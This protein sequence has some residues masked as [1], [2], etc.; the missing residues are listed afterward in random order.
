MRKLSDIFAERARAQEDDRDT[1]SRS[2]ARTERLTEAERL[3]RLA[4]ELCELSD[5]QLRRLELPELVADAVAD[6]RVIDSPP[7]HARQ[8]K[9]VRRH[10]RQVDVDALERA[11]EGE[12]RPA[13][14]T[15]AVVDKVVA[16]YE[17]L[18]TE[19]DQ[20]VFDFCNAHPD[21]DHGE[22]RTLLRA[23]EKQRLSKP[24]VAPLKLSAVRRVIDRLRRYA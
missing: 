8:L 17:K 23:A 24:D 22:L 3:L 16:L 11:L 6:A 12:V 2:D 7:A 14:V 10:L 20:A 1:R 5:K 9:I 21:L 19:G 4:R 18:S 15:G 13:R